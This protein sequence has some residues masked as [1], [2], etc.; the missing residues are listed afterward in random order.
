MRTSE[1]FG[2]KNLWIFRNLRFYGMSARTSS[3]EPMRI[4]FGKGRGVKFL[5][6]F[7]QSSFMDGYIEKVVTDDPIE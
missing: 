2:A 4:F 7:V 5:R 6:D 3:I 1:L